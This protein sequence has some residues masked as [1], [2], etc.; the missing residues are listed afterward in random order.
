MNNRAAVFL[1]ERYGLEQLL[2]AAALAEELGFDFVSVGDSILAKPRYSPIPVLAAIAGRT[3]RLGLATGILQ[4]HMRNPVLL[5]QEWATLD[6]L[7]GGRTTLGVGLGTG[8]AE[9]VAREYEVVGIP[10]R[11]RARAF[12]EA[13]QLV[14]RL[15]LEEQVTFEGTVFRCREVS[16]GFRPLQSPHPPVV[17]ACGG[18]VP[19]RPGVGPNDF[20]TEERAGTYHGPFERVARL[21]DGWITGI[22]TPEEYARAWSLIRQIAQERHGRR[23]A[24]DFRRVLNCFIHVN[25]DPK[26][27]RREAVSLLQAYHR[28]PF[29]DETVERWTIYGPPERC[30]ER[31]A[32]YVEAGVTAFQLVI[33]AQDQLAQIR[34]IAEQVRPLLKASLNPGLVATA[35]SRHAP[36]SEPR[37]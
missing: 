28:L 9:L 24:A 23:L 36:G 16:I 20:F 2:E 3:R 37:R 4:P 33:A 5:A 22:V 12:D 13:I 32:A 31:M 27:A 8:P 29:D 34:A 6:V 30:A 7:S 25:A 15:W 19:T 17:I 1:G 14:K 21:G 11:R 18:Y 35:A 26:A 10:R